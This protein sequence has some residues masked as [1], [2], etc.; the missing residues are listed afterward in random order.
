MKVRITKKFKEIV[1]VAQMPT[2][3]Q[4]IQDMSIVQM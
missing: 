4:L 1:T 2:V 3:R